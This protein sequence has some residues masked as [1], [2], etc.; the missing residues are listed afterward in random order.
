MKLVRIVS[1]GERARARRF[2][3]LLCGVV[4]FLSAGTCLYCGA[5]R[6]ASAATTEI[7]NERSER[8]VVVPGM[9]IAFAAPEDLAPS[10]RFNGFESATRAVEVVVA[11]IRAPFRQI[12]DAF[13]E[14]NLK[15][16][17]IE[18]R[19]RSELKINGA[20]AVLIKALHPEAGRDWGKWILLLAGDGGTY[21]VNGVFASGDDAAAVDVERMLKSAFVEAASSADA[22]SPEAADLADEEQDALDD[23]MEAA[24]GEG[25]DLAALLG[26]ASGDAAGTRPVSRDARAKTVPGSADA[27]EDGRIR[28]P[29]A[30]TEAAGG[31][32]D[33]AR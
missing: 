19:S 25:V 2:R 28:S 20:D 24:S 27:R 30:R 5:E 29:D 21:V 32:S 12:A 6:I 3:A 10:V 8:H 17:G 13:T 22:E 4:F 14:A 31:A 26:L 1:R 15:T 18:V 9:E 23:A 7:V 16:R 33:D 11:D